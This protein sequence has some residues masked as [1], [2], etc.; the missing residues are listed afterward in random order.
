MSHS[1]HP[2]KWILALDWTIA[3]TGQTLNPPPKPEAMQEVVEYISLL[4]ERYEHLLVLYAKLRSDYQALS[5]AG[6]SK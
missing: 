6:I 5:K 4:N 3:A 2:G 1:E